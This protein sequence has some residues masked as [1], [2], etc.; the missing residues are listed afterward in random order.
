MAKYAR[1]QMRRLS[2]LEESERPWPIL[3]LVVSVVSLVSLLLSFVDG[4]T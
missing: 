2:N 3:V 1:R 4:L